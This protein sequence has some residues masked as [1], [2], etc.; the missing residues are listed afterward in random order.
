MGEI[1]EIK[2]K[3]K[4]EIKQ[5]FINLRA[6]GHS[7][8]AIAS[9]LNLSP[10]TVLNWEGEFNEEISR[11]KAVE[12]ESLY[13][14]FHLTKKHRLKEI[15]DQLQLI[16]QE[17]STRKLADISTDR[18]LDLNLRYLERAEREYIE[19]KFLLKDNRAVTKLDSQGIAFELYLLLLRFRAGVIDSTEASRENSILQGMLKAEEQGDIQEKVEELK[20]LLEG[21]K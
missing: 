5:D 12:L 6:K 13:E 11:L 2:P 18:L 21:N 15:S 4:A 16:Q 7:I 17:L 1:V 20:T 8:R 19:P 14:Q 10:Q 3:G 9:E